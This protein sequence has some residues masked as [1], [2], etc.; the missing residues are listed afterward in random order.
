MVSFETLFGDTLLLMVSFET[1]FGD[2]LLLLIFVLIIGTKQVDIVVIICSGSRCGRSS[3][4]S[5][6]ATLQ[7]PNSGFQ[8]K[9]ESLQIIGHFL[10]LFVLNLQSVQ[11][12]DESHFFA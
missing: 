11:F 5:R 3:L 8:G 7:R 6:L 10:E 2:T 1:L 12:L 9:N 4:S